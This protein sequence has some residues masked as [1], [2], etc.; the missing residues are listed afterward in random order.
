M[1]WVDNFSK[2]RGYSV[3]NVDRGV[4][5]SCLWTGASVFR[6]ED[7][8]IS[9]SVVLCAN[10]SVRPAMPE[11]ILE[12]QEAVALTV[13]SVLRE[14]YMLFDDSLVNKYD[15]RTIP[16]KVDT[17]KFPE[18]AHIID[19]PM[20]SLDN[21]YPA[22]LMDINIGSN[23]GLAIILRKMYTE[24]G[25]EPGGSCDRYLSLNV[26]ENIFWRTLKV[27]YMLF[28]RIILL[29]CCELMYN[30]MVCR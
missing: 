16:L 20:N 15:V 1:L 11:N 4:Y 27:T 18:I 3:P 21:V 12:R 7:Q 26:D 5:A 30:L 13:Q 14:D 10:G 25:M 29:M 17:Q 6:C 8:T 22:G 2:N 19:H 9:D 23:R 28:L 24:H